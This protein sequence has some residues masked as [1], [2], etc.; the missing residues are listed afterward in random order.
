MSAS[1]GRLVDLAEQLARDAEAAPDALRRRDRALGRALG[2]GGEPGSI[3]GWLERLRPEDGESLGEQADRAGRVL[4]ALLFVA[5]LAVGGSAALALFWYDGTHPVNVVRVLGVFVGL[6]LL[7]VVGTVVLCLPEG[8]RRRVPGLTALQEALSLL[9]P[10]RW[11]GALRRVLPGSQRRAAERFAGLAQ[12][13]HRLYGDVEKWWLLSASQGFGVAFNLGALGVALALVTFTDLAFGWSTTLDVGAADF[14]AV[15]HA[16]SRPWAGLWPA[17]VPDAA[18]V[19]ATRYFRE[20]A[21]HDPAASAAWWPF[22]VASM[23]VYGLLPRVAFWVLA[24]V[25]LAFAVRRGLRE[26]PGVAA[27]RERLSSHLVETGA[28]EEEAGT[29]PVEDATQPTAPALEEGLRCRAIV[30]SGFP[31][32]D[33]AQAGA[34]LGVDVESLH[35]AGEADLAQD[36]AAIRALA[37]P[38]GDEPVVVVAKAWEPPVLE[39][40]DFL[41]DLRRAIGDGRGIVLV[42]LALSDAGRPVAPPAREGA[43][44]RHAVDRLGDPWTSVHA[45]RTEGP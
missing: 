42:P 5:G 16:L 13:H 18:L 39:L 38:G 29:A 27:L 4:S 2:E 43:V 31:L 6:Q 34:A 41:G 3:A 7:L 23:G 36:A 20:S 21:G 28:L 45:P 15:T 9:S 37:E 22:L 33:A 26:T 8:W 10:G 35:R 25:Q 1:I 12:R 24:R 30:W 32:A 11:Q 44:W 17:A 40:L 14:G 19:D